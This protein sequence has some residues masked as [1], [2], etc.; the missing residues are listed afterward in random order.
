MGVRPHIFRKQ[1]TNITREIFSKVV[2]LQQARESCDTFRK[3]NTEG[4][5]ALKADKNLNETAINTRA[6]LY[7]S[8]NN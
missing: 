4:R 2:H 8:R 3:S 7:A 6:C 1:I 5:R